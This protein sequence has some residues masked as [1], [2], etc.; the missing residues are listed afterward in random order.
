VLGVFAVKVIFGLVPLQMVAVLELVITGIGFTVTAIAVGLP[1][2]KPF[3][4]VGVIL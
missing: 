4:D 2:H 3:V 1:T